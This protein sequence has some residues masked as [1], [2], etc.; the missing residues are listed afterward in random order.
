M[1]GQTDTTPEYRTIIRCTPQ[2]E[3]AVKYDLIKLCGEFSAA[4]LISPDNASTLR[5]P[6]NDEVE[7]AARLVE[8]VANKVKRNKKDYVL[9]VQVLARKIDKSM[10]L[11]LEKVYRSLGEL[12][13]YYI[14]LL[15]RVPTCRYS[16]FFNVHQS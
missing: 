7:R 12:Y 11:E 15:R 4:G 5:N 10:V 14:V 13:I 2:L 3:D 6:H 16:V 8:L 9:F 1:A